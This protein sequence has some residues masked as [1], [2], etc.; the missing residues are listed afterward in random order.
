[1]T[2]FSKYEDA[3]EFSKKYEEKY[4]LENFSYDHLKRRRENEFSRNENG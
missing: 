3:V 2:T 1:M 4:C